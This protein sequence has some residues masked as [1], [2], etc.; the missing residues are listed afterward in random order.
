MFDDADYLA[1]VHTNRFIPKNFKVKD[2]PKKRVSIEKVRQEFEQMTSYLDGV[3]N[4]G[5]KIQVR[6]M[7]VDYR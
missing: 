1:E 7:D 4:E 2:T 5:K 6:F 3:A